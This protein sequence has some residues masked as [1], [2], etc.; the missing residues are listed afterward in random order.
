MTE[1][2]SGVGVNGE[3]DDFAARYD[4]MAE[5]AMSG[6]I[7]K[8]SLGAVLLLGLVAAL[9]GAAWAVLGL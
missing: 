4:R 9:S 2:R 3:P 6:W 5:G 7:A 8:V 1:D